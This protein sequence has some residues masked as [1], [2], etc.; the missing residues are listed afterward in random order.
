M[1]DKVKKI[2]EKIGELLQ[3]NRDTRK[4]Y[5]ADRNKLHQLRGSVDYTKAVNRDLIKTNISLQEQ[6]GKLEK[7]SARPRTSNHT[8]PKEATKELQAL[9]V[10]EEQQKTSKCTPPD[11]TDIHMYLQN[12]NIST[13]HKSR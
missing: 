8:P 3:Q 4:S 6:I 13:N 1:E 9:G 10:E 7:K 2:K 11:K 5:K 12:S